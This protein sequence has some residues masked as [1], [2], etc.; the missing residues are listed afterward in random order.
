MTQK[1]K[2]HKVHASMM[3]HMRRHLESRD[4][5]RIQRTGRRIHLLRL[6][7]RIRFADRAGN[8]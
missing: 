8:A 7:Y 2:F 1:E 5:R 4:P 3:V 6:A